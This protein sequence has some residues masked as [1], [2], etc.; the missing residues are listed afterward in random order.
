MSR[1]YTLIEI[2]VAVSI[3]AFISGGVMISLNSYSSRQKLN[4]TIEEVTSA[5]RLSQNF[6]KTR[7]LPVGSGE[8]E[9]LYVRLQLIDGKYLVADANGVGD[10]YFST[11]VTSTEI[12]VGS[13]P[14]VLYFWAG[15][16]KL[17]KDNAGTMYGDSEKA[18]FY[19]KANS[20]I[21]NYGKLEVSSLGQI[22]LVGIF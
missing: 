7:Q 8:T 11:V 21:T 19:V 4:K 10:S 1:A 15:S 16:G 12:G 3:I 17:S 5:V 13:T 2:M 9:L 14:A 18:T 20:D 22:N 6:A